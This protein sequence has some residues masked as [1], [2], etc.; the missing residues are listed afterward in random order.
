MVSIQIIAVGEDKI[1]SVGKIRVSPKGEVYYIQKY[2]NLVEAKYS[3]HVSGEIH[4]T[5]K[6]PDGTVEF[7]QKLGQRRPLKDFKGFEFFQTNAFGL[8]S[9]PNMFNEFSMK[10][11]D[12]IFAVNMRRFKGKSFNLGVGM[13]TEEGLSNLYRL[14]NEHKSYQFYLYT[15]CYPMIAIF[16]MDVAKRN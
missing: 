13:L 1:Y 15:D 9:L 14:W 11:S 12:G 4:Q 10:S 8:D 3:R 16:A 7:Y 2:L 5:I 6:R